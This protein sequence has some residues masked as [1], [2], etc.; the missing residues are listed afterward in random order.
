MKKLAVIM[1]ALFLGAFV[2]G[3]AGHATA[4]AANVPAVTTAIAQK[5]A[6]T[7]VRWYRYHWRHYHYYHWKRCTRWH[8]IGYGRVRRWCRYY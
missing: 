3:F 2:F 8:Y 5:T 7:Q 6:S 1:F 4:G